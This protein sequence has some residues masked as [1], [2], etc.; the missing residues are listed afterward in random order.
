M[1]V[2]AFIGLT[3]TDVKRVLA[4]S[5]IAHAGFIL[6]GVVGVATVYTGLAE[7][8]IG[9]VASVLFYLL[10][11]G[12]AT[13]GA[14]AIITLVRRS[15]SEATGYAAWE[16]LGR[17]NPV[18]AVVMTIFLLSMA[19]IPLTGGFVGKVLVFISAWNGG[20]V[21]LVLLAVLF[22]LVTAG[23]YFRIVWLMFG[24][25]PTPDTAVVTPGIGTWLVM[26]F[27]ALATVVLGVAPSWMIDL[28]G[29]SAGFVR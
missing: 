8:Q 16:G 25:E 2:G 26:Y 17:R 3:Q 28:I 5:S 10:A 29:A 11:Y 1:A 20:Y 18:L 4:Y 21:W 7:D 14:F 13:M 23:F 24:K 27:G 19:G 9:S 15:G 12:F 6:V 22:S